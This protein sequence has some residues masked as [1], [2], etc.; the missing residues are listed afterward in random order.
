MRT[1][2][3][4]EFILSLTIRLEFVGLLYFDTL[5]IRPYTVAQNIEP[6]TISFFTWFPREAEDTISPLTNP[7][8]DLEQPETIWVLRM[9]SFIKRDSILDHSAYGHL[10]CRMGCGSSPVTGCNNSR[11]RWRVFTVSWYE[12]EITIDFE[13]FQINRRKRRRKYYVIR[14]IQILA[15]WCGDTEGCR[16]LM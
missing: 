12:A 4:C 13:Q 11:R 16:S 2:R 3:V 14:T 8:A 10:L 7:I 9:E 15:Q 6:P 1:C 5:S